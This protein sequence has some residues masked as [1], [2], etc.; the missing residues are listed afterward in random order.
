MRNLNEELPAK[1]AN[2]TPKKE[3][4]WWMLWSPRRQPTPI[5]ERA[6]WCPVIRAYSIPSPPAERAL[7]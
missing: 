1:H 5:W 3:R 4:D 7:W 6:S 2:R